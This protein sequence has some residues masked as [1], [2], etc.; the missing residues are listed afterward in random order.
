MSWLLP[1]LV[2]MARALTGL[3]WPVTCAGCGTLDVA[4]CRSCAVSMSGKPFLLRPGPV[5][6]WGV[7]AYGGTAAR[8]IVAWKQHGRHDVTGWLGRVLAHAVVACL[9][10]GPPHASGA[11]VWLVPMPA[12]AAALRRRGADLPYDLARA[13]ARVFRDDRSDRS[14]IAVRAKRILRH[15]RVVQDQLGLDAEARRRNLAGAMTVRAVPRAWPQ[16]SLSGRKCI[17]VD[18]VVTTGASV[19]EAV[20]VLT[21]KGAHVVGVCCLSVTFKQQG[22]LISPQRTNLSSWNAPSDP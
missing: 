2:L 16:R 17:V 10:E 20:R 9:N 11:D 19:D 15:A 8:L 22:V 7:S 14:Q 1:E 21:A 18:D 5:P 4:V 12:R 13:A 6:V 3:I